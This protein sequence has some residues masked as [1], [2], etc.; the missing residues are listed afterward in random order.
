[1]EEKLSLQQLLQS[2]QL[3]REFSTKLFIAADPNHEDEFVAS[4]K[5]HQTLLQ[6]PNHLEK[7]TL[8]GSTESL[9]TENEI[10]SFLDSY[11]SENNQ[12]HENYNM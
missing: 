11:E 10:S 1:M 5:V 12:K 9:L 6:I 7:E 2:P 3:L 8:Q 4:E